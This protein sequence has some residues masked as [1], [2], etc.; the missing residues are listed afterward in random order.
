M[1]AIKDADGPLA[2]FAALR[3]EI[4]QF[5]QQ[6]NQMLALQLTIAGAVFGIAISH[7]GLAGVLM[8][9]PVVSYSLCARYLMNALA[10]TEIARYIRDEL[11]NRVPGGLG[12]ESWMLSNSRESMTYSLVLIPLLVTFPGV[13]VA[14]LSWALPYIYGQHVAKMIGL[15]IL[16]AISAAAAVQQIVIIIR[17]RRYGPQVIRVGRQRLGSVARRVP[18]HQRRGIALHK[19]GRR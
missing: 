15:V 9:V 5:N 13:S 19:L 17:H 12:W 8:I 3:D 1:A 6:Q 18:D 4:L 14:A 16:W 11:A 2:E 10:I 7:T